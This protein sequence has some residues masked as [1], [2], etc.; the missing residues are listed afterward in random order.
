MSTQN[1]GRKRKRKSRNNKRNFAIKVLISIGAVIVL[2]LGISIAYVIHLYNL[3]NY[4]NG[5]TP[6]PQGNTD[7][8]YE[9]VENPEDI[10]HL[11]DVIIQTGDTAGN[12]KREI[13]REDGVYNVLLLGLDTTEGK[14]LSD[15]IMIATLDTR[16]NAIKLTSVMRDILVQAPGHSPNKLNTVYQYGGISLLY[17]VLGSY[18]GIGFDG[19]VAV[20]YFALEDVV[21]A[22]GKVELYI[23]ET[24]ADFLNNSNYI[25]DAASRNLLPGRSQTVNGA[26]FVGYCRQRKTTADADFGRTKRQRYAL[27]ALYEKFRNSSITK[28]TSAIEAVLPYVTTDI[29]LTKMISLA[30]NAVSS[31]LGDIEQFRIPMNN[32]Y[33]DAKYNKMQVLDI[34]DYLEDN[35]KALHEFIFGDYKEKTK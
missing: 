24:E 18:F 27:N 14:Q 15:T 17:D 31:G 33:K 28:I 35:T 3:V 25:S 1:K 2:I 9:T 34:T 16:T 20:D 5:E 11:P 29:S 30:T 13:R 4:D 26:Q 12:D 7:V 21:N 23:T 19:Y 8:I 6:N 22:L 10:E 32:K